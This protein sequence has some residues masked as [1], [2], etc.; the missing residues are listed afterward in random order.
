[1]DDERLMMCRPTDAV[2]L[3][4]R[5]QPTGSETVCVTLSILAAVEGAGGSEVQGGGWAL[6]RKDNLNVQARP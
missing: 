6:R 5:D 2:R 3:A 4:T 1:M